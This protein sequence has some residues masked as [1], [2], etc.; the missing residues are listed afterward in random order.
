M[1]NQ[2]QKPWIV[3]SRKE[4]GEFF[5]VP[6][7]TVASWTNDGMPF[8]PRSY[9]LAE[10]AQWAI[11]TNRKIGWNIGRSKPEQLKPVED[12]P[13]LNGEESEGLERYRMARAQQ[14]EIKLA[15]KRGQVV[16]MDGFMDCARAI[17]SPFKRLAET[18]KRQ[19]NHDA[20]SLVEEATEEVERG[21]TQ[22]HGSDGD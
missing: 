7:G 10:I 3:G 19:Q 22:L 11:N 2:Q 20:F 14:E 18:F 5:R 1:G 13:M 12:D 9:D 6:S 21:L 17:L 8:Q 16:M 4:V 15:E